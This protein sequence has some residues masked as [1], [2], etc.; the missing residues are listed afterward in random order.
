M[1]D[2]WLIG[3]LPGGFPTKAIEGIDGISSVREEDRNP[4]SYGKYAS[5]DV[6]TVMSADN[7]EALD[8]VI[9][10]LHDGNYTLPA[11][12]EVECNFDFLK[13]LENGE[14]KYKLSDYFHNIKQIVVNGET[15][16]YDDLKK[17]FPESDEGVGLYKEAKKTNNL[18]GGSCRTRGC[19]T[20][21]E[22]VIMH[23]TMFLHAKPADVQ[24]LKKVVV[25][26][27]TMFLHAE[28]LNQH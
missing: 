13:M 25:M 15:Y 23:Q 5:Y 17:M 8:E 4:Q 11:D 3:V 14:N 28:H 1:K 12:M 2:Q 18:N 22:V 9:K 20:S 26:H 10:L 27:Q 6:W 16:T 19:A 24:L 7:A 21:E